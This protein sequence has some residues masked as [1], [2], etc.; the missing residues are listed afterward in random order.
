MES[1]LW[2]LDYTTERKGK[3]GERS[4]WFWKPRDRYVLLNDFLL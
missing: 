1:A 2:G 3:K 4:K